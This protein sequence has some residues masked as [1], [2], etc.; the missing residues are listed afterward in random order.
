M[1]PILLIAV[2]LGCGLVATAGVFQYL[3]KMPGAERVET[4]PVLVAGKDININEPLDA[5]NVQMAEWPKQQ[6]PLGA[7]SDLKELEG[8]YARVRLYP[9]EPILTAKIMGVDDTAGSLKVPVGY[10]VVS[11]RVTSES[12]VSSLIEPGDRVDVIAVLRES[13]ANPL[14]TAKTI[15][16]AV[17]VFAVNAEMGRSLDRDKTLDAARTVSLLLTPEQVEKLTMASDM[18]TIKLSLRSPDDAEVAETA[19]CNA[20]KVYGRGD[21]ADEVLS[22][23]KI[24]VPGLTSR[25]IQQPRSVEP[26]WTME[27][28]SPQNSQEYN[29]GKRDDPPEAAKATDST[30]CKDTAG[31]PEVAACAI[32]AE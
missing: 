21:V 19:G 12:S 29:W 28:M 18:G 13:R 15:L 20:D 1:R 9:G 8:K 30:A 10:R 2:A 26:Q 7:L 11:V 27:I 4:L 23:G 25:A 31:S 32:T 22:N 5:E 17:R 24:D 3:D 16:K 6:I 14:P